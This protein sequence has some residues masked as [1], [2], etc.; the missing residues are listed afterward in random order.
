MKKSILVILLFA[1][2][3]LTF[4]R[5]G[6]AGNSFDLDNVSVPVELIMGGGPPKDGIPSLD[7]PKFISVDE[8]NFLEDSDRVLAMNYKGIKKAYP[9]K[10]LNYHEIVND[11][12]NSH[13]IAI[14]YCP[15]CRSGIAFSA[16]IKGTKHSFGVSGLLYNSDVLLYDRETESLWSQIMSTAISGPL[17]GY[18]LTA[19]PLRNT[20]WKDWKQQ[21]PDSLI[22]STE[23]GYRRDYSSNPYRDYELDN[24]IWFPVTAKND[25]FHP[26]A[27]VVGIEIDGQFKAY[28]FSEL[29]QINGELRDD[30]AGKELTIYYNK[31]HES[32]SIYDAEGKELASITTFWFA[33]Y[34]FH[35]DGLVFVEK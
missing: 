1:L 11:D 30:F 23:T 25:S 9:I 22:L 17:K 32:A 26:K 6:I 18:H 20:T 13:P 8:V 31:Q 15:L 29:D 10:I 4:N 35:P 16:N 28:P 19:I 2:S 7:N 27:L 33:W 24:S 21:H 34:A 5:L 14:T 12:F 3:Y